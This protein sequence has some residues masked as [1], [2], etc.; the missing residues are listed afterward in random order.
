[1]CLQPQDL[2]LV[3]NLVLESL[4]VIAYMLIFHIDRSTAE[5][6]RTTSTWLRWTERDR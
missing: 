5:V 6:L 4:D 3:S 1:M 2:Q